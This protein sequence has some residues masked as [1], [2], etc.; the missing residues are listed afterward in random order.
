M[1]EMEDDGNPLYSALIEDY[2]GN[3]IDM[4]IDPGEYE[5]IGNNTT[6]ID[7]TSGSPEVIREGAGKILF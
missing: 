4:I 1:M 3:K 5:F 6:I 7:F 2:Y